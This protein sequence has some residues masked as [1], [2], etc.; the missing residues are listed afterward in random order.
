[1]GLL[2]A[3]LCSS[4]G[5]VV[6]VQRTS[7]PWTPGLG[8]KVV[9][10]DRAGRA[11]RIGDRFCVSAGAKIPIVPVENSPAP[12]TG[13]VDPDSGIQRRADICSGGKTWKRSTNSN[14]KDSVF[15][16]SAI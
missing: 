2:A 15:W 4:V 14:E 9:L 7:D 5:G 11:I 8:L 1:M 6:A 13:G 16:Q 3:H 12:W 10:F